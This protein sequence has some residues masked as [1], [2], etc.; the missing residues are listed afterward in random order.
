MELIVTLHGQRASTLDAGDDQ[1][2]SEAPRHLKRYGGQGAQVPH[3]HIFVQCTATMAHR[4]TCGAGRRGG[5]GLWMGHAGFK[6][7]YAPRTYG[8]QCVGI[9]INWVIGHMLGGWILSVDF[10]K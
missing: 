1:W 2:L 6:C 8:T 9:R 7:Q 5:E 3:P 10:R 4:C